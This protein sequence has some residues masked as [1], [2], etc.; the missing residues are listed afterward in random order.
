MGENLG[1]WAI[2]NVLSGTL[3]ISLLVLEAVR[4]GEWL[5]SFRDHQR[6]EETELCDL[7]NW[8]VVEIKEHWHYE[9]GGPYNGH[10][11][12]Y[13]HTDS[14]WKIRPDEVPFSHV[15]IGDYGF[16]M[17]YHPLR[18]DFGDGVLIQLDGWE[19]EMTQGCEARTSNDP[20]LKDS[21]GNPHVRFAI[22][23]WQG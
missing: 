13:V 15:E 10:A 18:V 23:E 8:P 5:H 6:E 1:T 11:L 7:R 2:G 19:Y 14:D 20:F 9:D 16:K 17:K 22:N 21:N 3:T 12:C 4:A